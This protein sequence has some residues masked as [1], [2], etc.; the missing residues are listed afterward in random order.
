MSWAPSLDHLYQNAH[1]PLAA[2]LY[3][4]GFE[5]DGYIRVPDSNILLLDYAIVPKYEKK[6]RAS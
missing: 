1:K 3:E 4:D 2:K 5:I 6:K